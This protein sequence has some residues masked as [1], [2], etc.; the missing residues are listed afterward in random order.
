MKNNKIS[1]IFF[2]LLAIIF[3]IHGRNYP[4]GSL[5]RVEF[6]FFPLIVSILCLILSLF[7]FFVDDNDR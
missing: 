5:A 2:M 3:L 4:I 7:L 1:S 6:G